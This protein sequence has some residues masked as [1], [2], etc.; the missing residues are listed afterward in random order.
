MERHF[1]NADP[2]LL[3]KISTEA[4]ITN[5]MKSNNRFA[6]IPP[7]FGVN[8]N[9]GGGGV[10]QT[11]SS[12]KTWTSTSSWMNRRYVSLSNKEV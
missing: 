7:E 12:I 4:L 1:A 3:E 9:K 2:N 8:P 11:A 6:K 10:C 5:Y